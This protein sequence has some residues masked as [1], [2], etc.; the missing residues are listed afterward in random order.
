MNKQIAALTARMIL[1]A[2]AVKYSAE[3]PFFLSSGWAS[4]VYI[5]CGSLISFP[6]IRES[7]MD[8]AAQT[9]L[10]RVG[11]EQFD[12]VAGVEASGIAYAAWIAER[13]SLPLLYVRRKP[14]GFGREAP[15]EGALAPG[16]RVLLVDD[17]TTDGRTKMSRV[18][19]LRAI[20][21]RADHV[22]VM[23]FYDVFPETQQLLSELGISLHYLASWKH[24]LAAARASGYFE[25][26][27]ADEVQ[28]FLEAP[29]R[30]SLEHGG[31]GA[32][33]R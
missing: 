21:A 16:R 4:P 13:L 27:A 7:L 3:Q 31:I 1:E 11:F 22:L 19:T 30:W 32:F 26:A 10:A 29:A 14:L 17:V 25:P 12:I 5:D 9:V 23:F 2:G 8:L 28:R 33:P 6:R 24:I 18:R 15:I 20:E